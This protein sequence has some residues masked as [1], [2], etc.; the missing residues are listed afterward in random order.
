MQGFWRKVPAPL[1]QTPPR[2]GPDLIGYNIKAVQNRLGH[3]LP[4]PTMKVHAHVSPQMDDEDAAD[5][6]DRARAAG[7]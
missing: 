5:V 3:S 1:H 2:G 6:Y 7:D 4:S